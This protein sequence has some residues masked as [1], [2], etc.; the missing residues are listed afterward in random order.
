MVTPPDPVRIYHFTHIR[1]LRGIIEDGLWSDA[2]CRRDD[3][4]EVQIGSAG[5][6]QRRLQ[7][8][9]GDV[10]PR[11]FV[12]DCVPWYFG[13]R[14]PMMYTLSRNNYEYQ[15]GFD[16]VVY[17]VSSVPRIVALGGEWVASDRNAALYMAEFTDDEQSLTDHISWDVIVARYWSDYPDGADLRAAEF[18]VHES[19]PWEAVEA[20]VTK[21]E[22]T[23]AQVE[24]MVAGLRH[25]P[26]VV[27]RPGWYF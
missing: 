12:G 24:A 22:E 8:P 9:V 14:S 19:V 27:V 11:G 1:N 16:E 3:L 15:D 21:T 5:I 20:I 4:T 6:R 2:A 13:P 7:L 10:G 18:L 17:L 26:R 23:R 25:S